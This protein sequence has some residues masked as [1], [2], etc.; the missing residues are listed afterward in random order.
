MISKLYWLGNVAKS[1]IIDEILKL[2][3]GPEPVTVFD[4][5][6][7]DAG[8]WPQILA[9]HP[10]LTMIGYEPYMP[11]CQRARERL[12]DC[13]AQI[14]SGQDIYTLNIQADFI[15]SFSVFEHVVNREEFLGQAK[16][17]LAPTGL[18]YLNY[19]DGHFRNLLE[20]S[21]LSTWLPALR[22]W[23]RTVVSQPL[24]MLGQQSHYQRRVKAEEADTL[25]MKAGFRIEREEYHNLTSLKE[26]SKSI[27]EDLRQAYAQWWLESE[28]AL[29]ENFRVKL[30]SP[31]YCDFTNLWQQMVSRTLCLHHS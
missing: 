27:P 6:C 29:N 25:V 15:V 16:R 2:S 7:G 23:G 4:Y 22:A 13:S 21:R 30:I 9:D 10:H 17:F 28:K 11:S 5:G 19:D 8:D 24:A 31:V 20:V 18:F 3:P 12:K 26:L 14:L 1:R